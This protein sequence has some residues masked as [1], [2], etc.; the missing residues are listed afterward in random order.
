MNRA[1]LV[2]AVAETSGLD[3]ESVDKVLKQLTATIT[4]AVAEGETVTI[5]GF[6]K[7]TK[8]SRAA[9]QGRNPQ[10]GEP[11]QIAASTRAKITPLK[12]FHA[13]VECGNDQTGGAIR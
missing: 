4:E 3:R 7:F 9:R 8:T 12:A 6:A 1:E 13:A 10:T 5:P 11:I 2:A